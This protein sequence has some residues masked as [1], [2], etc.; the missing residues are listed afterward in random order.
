MCRFE[1][2]LSGP[3]CLVLILLGQLGTRG[4]GDGRDCLFFLSRGDVRQRREDF[5]VLHAGGQY[6]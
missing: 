5:T 4:F 3:F 6:V 1:M 2:H